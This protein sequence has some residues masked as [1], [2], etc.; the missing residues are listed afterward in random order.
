MI[1]GIWAASTSPPNMSTTDAT[2][3]THFQPPHPLHRLYS[4]TTARAPGASIL[5]S[6]HGSSTPSPSRSITVSS[7][8][9]LS[10]TSTPYYGSL[11]LTADFS[12]PL[13]ATHS[14]VNQTS[15]S[16]NSLPLC[17]PLASRPN[18]PSTSSAHPHPHRQ[19]YHW[20][21]IR[22]P[23]RPTLC[24]QS[25]YHPQNTATFGHVLDHLPCPYPVFAATQWP[26]FTIL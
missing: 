9:L 11:M 23:P 22:S 10:P 18:Q 21:P 1:R 19:G 3:A 17:C 13:H 4:V 15:M 24:L 16:I 8:P 25:L 20:C 12:H 6:N 5:S 2:V 14:A 26:A 7:S